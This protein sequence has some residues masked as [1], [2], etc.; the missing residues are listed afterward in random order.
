MRDSLGGDGENLGGTPVFQ[1]AVVSQTD[2]QLIGSQIPSPFSRRLTVDSFRP[3]PNSERDGL[4]ELMRGV[5]PRPRVNALPAAWRALLS[6][7]N[8]RSMVWFQPKNVSVADRQ[9]SDAIE[10]LVPLARQGATV[11]VVLGLPLSQ[12]HQPARH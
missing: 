10:S 12:P 1:W 8:Q 7:P 11:W 5:P 2:A 6:G 4:I 9:L 3:A